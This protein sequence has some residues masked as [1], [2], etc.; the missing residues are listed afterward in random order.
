MSHVCEKVP[1]TFDE[2]V[3]RPTFTQ[4]ALKWKRS[5][6]ET[7]NKNTCFEGYIDKTKLI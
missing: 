3:S 6:K 5:Q 2:V 1:C 4:I 7:K